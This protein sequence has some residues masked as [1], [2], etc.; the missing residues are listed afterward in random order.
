MSAI[1]YVIGVVLI[2]LCL[3]LIVTVLL[4][5]SRSAGLSGAI[6]GAADNFFGK[7]KGRTMEQKIEKI[8]KICGIAFF[9]LSLAVSIFFMFKYY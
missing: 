8:T 2:L 6:S 9:V 1:Q 5:E 3:V 7:A 4:Q